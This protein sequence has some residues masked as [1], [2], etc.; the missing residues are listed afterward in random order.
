MSYTVSGQ[1]VNENNQAAPTGSKICL[2][3]GTG[4]SHTCQYG[5]QT[6][7]TGGGFRFTNVEAGRYDVHIVKPGGGNCYN[8]TPSPVIVDSNEVIRITASCL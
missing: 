5:P 4:A 6:V 2:G 8:A 3:S 7:G 1:V